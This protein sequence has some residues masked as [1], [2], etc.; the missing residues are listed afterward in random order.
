[1]C[2]DISV[3]F[4]Q[5][6]ILVNRKSFQSLPHKSSKHHFSLKRAFRFQW[7][8]SGEADRV[9]RG[10]HEDF[11]GENR[12]NCQQ[13]IEYYRSLVRFVL[14]ATLLSNSSTCLHDNTAWVK[15][16]MNTIKKI[17]FRNI[18]TINF[19]RKLFFSTFRCERCRK[20]VMKSKADK[21][22]LPCCC[23]SWQEHVLKV[24]TQIKVC[25]AFR[26]WLFAGGVGGHWREFAIKA[27]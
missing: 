2:V 1:M 16:H 25:N 23:G 18:F 26:T 7:Q 13:V 21:R 10:A 12:W 15:L 14:L 4:V 5:L 3:S 8:F 20:R 6:F 9:G 27:Q 11:F 17:C 19:H 22:C 24:K